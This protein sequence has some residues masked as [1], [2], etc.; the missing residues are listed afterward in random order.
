MMESNNLTV[1]F[2][3]YRYRHEMISRA[4]P[5]DLTER[6]IHASRQ[7]QGEEALFFSQRVL[8]LSLKD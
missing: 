5:T 4:W 1:Y 3:V 8:L 7:T 6:G 2:R